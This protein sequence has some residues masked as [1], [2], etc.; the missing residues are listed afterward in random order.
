MDME[1]LREKLT[2]IPDS[3]DWIRDV[4]ESYNDYYVYG[5][6]LEEDPNVDE[7]FKGMGYDNSYTKRMVIVLSV[8]NIRCL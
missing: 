4:P 1:E 3:F 6:G 5:I 7:H 8:D 2:T